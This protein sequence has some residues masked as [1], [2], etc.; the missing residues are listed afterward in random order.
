MKV[1]ATGNSFRCWLDGFEL[2]TLP[3]ASVDGKASDFNP[4][5]AVNPG[6]T[7]VL[8]AQVRDGNT[9]A[10]ERLAGRFLEALRRFGHGRLPD[11][12][13]DMIDT[14]D[15]V[16]ITLLNA[17]ERVH[18]VDAD[19]KGNFLAYMRKI[20]VNKVRDEVRRSAKKPQITV[21]TDAIA[22]DA[23]S[24]LEETLEKE[25]L[26]AYYRALSRL[27]PRQR[28]ALILRIEHG[29]SYQQVA[30]E[31]GSPSADAARMVIARGLVA[32][33]KNLPKH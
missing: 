31:I 10:R 18:S 14:D 2:G 32:V 16:Q 19:K 28:K 29:F 22:S 24:P 3:K 30:G 7:A 1:T 9:S 20:L 15:L 17:L 12:A 5:K 33:T 13:R 27:S 8:I 26:A 6:S 11:S 25:S 4:L 23:P 21:L